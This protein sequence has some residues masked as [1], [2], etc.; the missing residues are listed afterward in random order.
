MGLNH[1]REWIAPAYDHR[2]APKKPEEKFFQDIWDVPSFKIINAVCNRTKHM[3]PGPV[4]TS[5]YG[6]PFDDWPDIDSVRDFDLGP[7]SGY[8]VDGR[9]FTR[10]IEDVI[11]FYRTKWFE[12]GSP[13]SK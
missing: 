6:I 4:T 8:F 2:A 9:D 1:L 13:L 7:V 5:S 12:R 11:A 10:I 3:N